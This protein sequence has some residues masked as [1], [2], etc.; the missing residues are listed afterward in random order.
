[1]AFNLEVRSHYSVYYW[2]G[3]RG[4]LGHFYLRFWSLGCY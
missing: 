2:L 4:R 1:M 3:R